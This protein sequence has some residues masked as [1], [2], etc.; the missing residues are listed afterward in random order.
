MEG[1]SSWKANFP[2]LKVFANIYR[3]SNDTTAQMSW[4]LRI[5]YLMI[6]FPEVS[7][8][9][10]AESSFSLKYNSDHKNQIFCICYVINKHPDVCIA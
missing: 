10:L 7:S 5:S 2:S 3:Y 1:T 8:K 4:A 6:K 9:Q